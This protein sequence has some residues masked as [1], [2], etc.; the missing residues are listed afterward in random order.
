MWTLI[1]SDGLR[2]K[3]TEYLGRGIAKQVPAVL[4]YGASYSVLREQAKAICMS[5][6]HDTKETYSFEQLG[7]FRLKHAW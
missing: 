7:E 4:G 6:Q 2:T 3:C 5:R 1:W